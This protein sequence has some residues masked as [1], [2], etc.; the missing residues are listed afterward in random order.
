MIRYGRAVS[1]RA[2]RD[3]L[4]GE[5]PIED[6]FPVRAE[7]LDEDFLD[8]LVV[9]VA[10]IELARPWVWP[11]RS[12][13]KAA[14][15]GGLGRRGACAAG[16]GA[17]ISLR[18]PSGLRQSSASQTARDRAV[19]ER[20]GSRRVSRAGIRSRSVGGSC[21]R[22]SGRHRSRVRPAGLPTA[23][24]KACRKPISRVWRSRERV[25]QPGSLPWAAH[26]HGPLERSR[27]ANDPG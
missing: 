3:G 4:E 5:L 18:P 23:Y 22:S 7:R 26:S 12:A 16:R 9:L 21:G 2:V 11:G 10:G 25:S 8:G 1:Y 6:G 17:L 27:H 24:S 14:A 13:G 20:R 15:A 19:R